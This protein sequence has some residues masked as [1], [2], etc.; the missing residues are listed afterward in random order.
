LIRAARGGDGAAFADLLRNEYPVAFRLAY[1][2][3]HDIGEAEDAV[4]D[5]AF[6]SGLPGGSN[7]SSS[8]W[9]A[10]HSWADR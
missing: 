4:Q 2:M 6:R 5:G 10:A 7:A 8:S 9:P 3:L 1:G